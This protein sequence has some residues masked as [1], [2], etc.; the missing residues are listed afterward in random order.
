MHRRIL[1]IGSLL[2]KHWKKIVIIVNPEYVFIS[3]VTDCI[4]STYVKCNNIVTLYHKWSK[5]ILVFVEQ[6][7]FMPQ[8]RLDK[9]K[10]LQAL[11]LPNAI[12]FHRIWNVFFFFNTLHVPMFNSTITIRKLE[13]D[14]VENNLSLVD[15]YPSFLYC[16]CSPKLFQNRPCFSYERFWQNFLGEWGNYGEIQFNAF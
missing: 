9:G 2:S 4:L 16:S 10:I 12:F 15:F 11:H 7:G 6:F 1:I 8:V 14:S 5:I 3:F 13:I